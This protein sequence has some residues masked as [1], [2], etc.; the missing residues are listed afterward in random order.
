MPAHP[1]EEPTAHADALTFV[2]A[3]RTETRALLGTGSD[4]GAARALL[5]LR[6]P[7]YRP[8]DAEG[9][10]VRYASYRKVVK[11]QGVPGLAASFW[12]SLL[13]FLTVG[14]AVLLALLYA[15]AAFGLP[16]GQDLALLAPERFELLRAI[17]I[18]LLMPTLLM[19][20]YLVFHAS[21]HWRARTHGRAIL[22]IARNDGSALCKGLPLR[23]PFHGIWASW[24]LLSKCLEYWLY[25]CLTIAIIG[26]WRASPSTPN[27]APAVLAYAV[28][29][30]AIL[31]VVRW[32][33]T[34]WKRRKDL[35][36]AQ[37]YRDADDASSQEGLVTEHV[38]DDDRLRGQERPTEEPGGSD[39]EI[40]TAEAETIWRSDFSAGPGA[41]DHLV[42][43]ERG[44]R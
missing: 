12:G 40:V 9:N 37:L 34:L 3:F 7:P 43:P 19:P 18:L 25:G 22:R 30:V 42:D 6:I 16:V 8:R 21:V 35:L 14:A 44:E 23:S 24:G 15:L 41:T 39:E 38:R 32:R 2:R 10:K 28:P 17:E 29:V 27:I 26:W 5:A 20:L 36:N 33:V 1:T 13:L 4:D 11:D 31:L